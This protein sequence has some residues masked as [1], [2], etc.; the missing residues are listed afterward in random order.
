M[1]RMPAGGGEVRFLN[2]IYLLSA[3]VTLKSGVWIRGV[4]HTMMLKG[5]CDLTA[6]ISSG[7]IIT[8]NNITGFV[9]NNINGGG[10]EDIA[11]SG[12]NGFSLGKQNQFGPQFWQVNRVTVFNPPSFGFRMYNHG[13][14]TSTKLAVVAR[15]L[16]PIPTTWVGIDLISENDAGNAVTLNAATDVFTVTGDSAQLC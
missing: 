8:G 5:I 9:G 6:A 12:I 1:R 4:P 16:A 13:Q 15:G 14:V 2:S 11:T 3:P 10:I 7:T